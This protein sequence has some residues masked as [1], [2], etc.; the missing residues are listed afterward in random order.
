MLQNLYEN[1]IPSDIDKIDIETFNVN[2]QKNGQGILHYLKS[3][4]VLLHGKIYYGYSLEVIQ[5]SQLL[6]LWRANE[7]YHSTHFIYS[8]EF[9]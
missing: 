1:G 5:C 8:S 2:L 4:C 9:T 3:S 6:F 7:N